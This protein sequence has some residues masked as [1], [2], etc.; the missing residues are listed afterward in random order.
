MDRRKDRIARDLGKNEVKVDV[1]ALERRQVVY[2]RPVG[3]ESRL[4]SRQIFRGGM[5]RGKTRKRNL[6]ERARFLK[7]LLAARRAMPRP[8][9]K[10]SVVRWRSASWYTYHTI[11]LTG[12]M[13]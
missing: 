8:G 3:S 5:A 13:P 4:Q 7:V 10:A 1:G 6:E 11:S 2:A 12:T 9:R